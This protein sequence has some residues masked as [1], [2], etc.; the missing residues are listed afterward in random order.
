MQLDGNGG[1]YDPVK[2]HDYY[3]RHKK[4][5]GRKKASPASSS[6]S[7]SGVPKTSTSRPVLK[8]SPKTTMAQARVSRLKSKV[9]KLEGALSAARAALSKKRQTSAKETKKNSDGKTTAKERQDAKEYREKHQQ[10]IASKRKKEDSSKSSS[11][12]VDS[13]GVEELKTR[14]INIQSAL[15]DAKRQ[16]SNANHQLGQLAHSDLT[17]EPSFNEHFAHFHS[18]EGIPSK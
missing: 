6:P 11:K 12:S 9:S 14:I 2:A 5:K 13:M 3:E 8:L 4:L 10:E 1:G 7:S 16:L 15:K 18:A 17:S